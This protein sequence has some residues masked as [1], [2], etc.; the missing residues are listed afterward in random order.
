MKNS[1]YI[2]VVSCT[3]VLACGSKP[4]VIAPTS[5]TADIAPAMEEPTTRQS[6]EVV[7]EDFLHATRYTYL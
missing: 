4:K 2:V 7:V 5:P 6:H 1:I 3:L